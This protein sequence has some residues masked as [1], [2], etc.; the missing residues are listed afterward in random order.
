MSKELDKIY[1]LL[2]ARRDDV[3][4][5]GLLTAALQADPS[6]T[7]TPALL[8]EL[9][10]TLGS[11]LYGL[12]VTPSEITSFVAE[13][14]SKVTQPESVLDPMCG[15]GSLLYAVA[16]KTNAQVAHGVEIN[17]DAAKVAE[18]LLGDRADV[19]V[20]DA[21]QGGLP[22]AAAYD[23]V[24][25][26]PPFGARLTRPY[27]LSVDGQRMEQI[28]SDDAAVCFACEHMSPSGLAIVMV[29]SGVC[30]GTRSRR[31]R[32]A[33]EALGCAV[34]A[35]IQVPG[36]VLQKTHVE[37]YI[38]VIE[39]GEQG[40]V[41]VGQYTQD[42]SHQKVLIENCVTGREGKMTAQGRL[43]PWEG[44]RGYRPIEAAEHLQKMVP[45]LGF[46]AI[47]MSTLVRDV[48]RTNPAQFE[49][50]EPKPN[51][52]YL[53][54]VGSGKATTS[55]DALSEKLKD[56]VQ[57]QIDPDQADA[58]LVVE[59]LKRD[60]G[61]LVL[62]QARVGGHIQRIAV[63]ELIRLEFYLP[64]ITV[65]EK[66]MAAAD[67]VEA[68]RAE[69]REL[70]GAIWSSPRKIDSVID[71]IEAVNKEDRLEDW[72]D[73]LPFP[74]ASILWR[75][76]AASGSTRERYEILL[77]FFEA[78]AEFVAAVHLSA[79]S[80]DTDLWAEYGPGLQSALSK[81]NLSLDRA[82]FG[83][84]KG[85]VE[86][87]GKRVRPLFQESPEI[88]ENIYR[89][90]NR[91]VIE[92][93][94][95]SELRR[96]LQE[97]NSIR[98]AWSGHVG[99]VGERDARAIESEL[100]SLLQLCRGC[101][102][103][104]WQGYELLQPDQCRFVDGVFQYQLRRLAGTRTPFEMVT[105]E[106]IEAMEDGSLYLFDPDSDRGLRLLPFVRMMASPQTAVNACYFFSSKEKEGYR[107]VSYHFEQESG[108][109]QPFE[110]TTAAFERLM[111]VSRDDD[112]SDMVT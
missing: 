111:S 67:K 48:V 44:F 88:C 26:E 94:S 81:H 76:K 13:L 103:R 23:L 95:A 87:L 29:R 78:L 9:G 17:Q 90:R 59:L 4:A 72:L 30:I 64:A 27:S 84:W 15:S 41:F 12:W 21:F 47:P 75:Y 68:I 108:L 102:G 35:C 32:Q 57:L 28:Y 65:G 79:F 99:A 63:N 106:S 92:M 110:D 83:T 20:G 69:A 80:S 40:D 62:D 74:L 8:E 3:P 61:Q 96:A 54:C 50:L 49:R 56:Y 43:V 2:D 51:S 11:E 66:M 71:Q 37:S 18:S 55:Q 19:F 38:L 100:L 10:N 31:T 42:P 36:G 22:L 86:Y 45:R 77:H 104:E 24:V 91:S 7:I 60:I 58:Y 1:K 52:V 105:R 53:P 34:R 107:Y 85:V 70:E 46:N 16:D 97:A 14:A 89:T 73:T 98:N 109:T 25:A 93:L 5:S 112:S 82:T 33:V 6:I 101:M 39:N